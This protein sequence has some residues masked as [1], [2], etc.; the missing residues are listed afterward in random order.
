MA[1]SFTALS[2]YSFL[3]FN[4]LCAPCFAAMGAIKREMNNT[5]WFLGAIGY[6]CGF[7]YLVALVIYQLGTLFAGGGFGI[8]TVAAF[9]A[10][11]LFIY[12]LLR[13]YKESQRLTK[14]VKV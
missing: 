13:P 3:A 5:K 4:L 10:A 9:A 2:G 12:L 14:T 11:A 7:A 8:F 6:Q 1:A